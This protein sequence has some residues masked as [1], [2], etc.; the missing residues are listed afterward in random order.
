MANELRQTGSFVATSEDG[1]EYTI[2][3]FTKF[4]DV[5]TRR[6]PTRQIRGL[7]ELRTED[8]R[9][10]NHLEK[11]RYEIVQTGQILMSDDPDAP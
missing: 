1:E 11:G 3:E 10:V 4:I 5:G 6:D 7:R 8:G 2:H 9:A